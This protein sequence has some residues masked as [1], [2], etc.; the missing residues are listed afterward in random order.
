MESP[1]LKSI[2]YFLLY[3]FVI[4]SLLFLVLGI[5][6]PDMLFIVISV[7]FSICAVLIAL[8]NRQNLKN[9]FST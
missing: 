6:V 8:E 2:F 7:L 5:Y 4:A 3:A 9:P 1:L